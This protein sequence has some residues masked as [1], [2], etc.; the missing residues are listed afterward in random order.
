MP[1]AS[2]RNDVANALAAIDKHYE[3]YRQTHTTTR[4]P[5]GYRHV[6]CLPAPPLTAT[7]FYCQ[8]CGYFPGPTIDSASDN[9]AR[10]SA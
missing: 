1:D 5:D 10:Q 3:A 7:N 9:D 8:R 4:C 2:S 6:W